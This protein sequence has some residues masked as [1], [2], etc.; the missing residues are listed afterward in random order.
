MSMIAIAIAAGHLD[1]DA[2]DYICS[3]IQM[4]SDYEARSIL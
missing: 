1:S 2:D 4:G 3:A